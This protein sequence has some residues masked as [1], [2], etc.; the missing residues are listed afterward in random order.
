L[1]YAAFADHCTSVAYY[2]IDGK[3]HLRMNDDPCLL[4]WGAGSKNADREEGEIEQQEVE[5][6]DDGG[7]S[8]R[9]STEGPR[10]R[11]QSRA[12]GMPVS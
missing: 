6:E 12:I 3:V 9:R 2:I 8:G 4:A 7:V 11:S 5:Q 1:F 10:T